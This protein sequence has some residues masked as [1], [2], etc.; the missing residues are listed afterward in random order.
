MC[1]TKNQR[2][3]TE[4]ET[5]TRER[6]GN[7]RPFTREERELLIRFWLG[8]RMSDEDLRRAERLDQI[9]RRSIF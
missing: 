7:E 4:M 8:E 1:G 3:E 5:T 9:A 6:V 2:K